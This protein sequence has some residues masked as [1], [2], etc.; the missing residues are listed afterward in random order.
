MVKQSKKIREKQRL[1]KER[2]DQELL[3]NIQQQETFEF[4]SGQEVTKEGS[5]MTI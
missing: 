5:S 1:T 4:P 2:A 3:T